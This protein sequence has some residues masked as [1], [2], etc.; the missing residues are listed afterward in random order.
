MADELLQRFPNART[1]DL[2]IDDQI[3]IPKEGSSNAAEDFS[4]PRRINGR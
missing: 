2:R 3:I 4:E 1:F